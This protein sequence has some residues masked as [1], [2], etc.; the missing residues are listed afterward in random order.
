MCCRGS[1]SNALTVLHN[2]KITLDYNCII[3]LEQETE[4]GAQ[5][6]AIVHSPNYQCFV[7]NIGSSEMRERGV[8]P[9]NYMHYE[10]FLE[11][12][13]VEHLPRLDPMLLFDVT[14]IDRSILPSIEMIQLVDS[15]EAVLFGS[16]EPINVNNDNID[17]PVGRKWLNRVCDLHSMW[18]HINNGNEIFLS[19]KGDFKQETKLPELVALGAGKIFHSSE[20]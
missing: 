10:N 6:N 19:T 13:K 1:Q 8:R 17:S 11:A 9:D 14:F 15:I 4:I 5:V 7:V 16:V 2:M 3:H 12:A 20:L 18:C